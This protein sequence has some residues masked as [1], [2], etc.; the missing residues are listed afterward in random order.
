MHRQVEYRHLLA[1]AGAGQL[2][3]RTGPE[4]SDIAFLNAHHFVINQILH[5]AIERHVNLHLAVPVA[6]GHGVRRAQFDVHTLILGVERQ[7]AAALL[8][9]AAAHKGIGGQRGEAVFHR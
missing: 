1:I 2:M 5:V 3:R 8:F 4:Q 7:R 6:G 9:V